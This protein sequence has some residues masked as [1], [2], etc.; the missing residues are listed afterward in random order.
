MNKKIKRLVILA[1][2][3]TAQAKEELVQAVYECLQKL[4]G[5]TEYRSSDENTL[6]IQE[7]ELRY[8]NT[9]TLL[10][11]MMLDHNYEIIAVI[12]DKEELML[13]LKSFDGYSHKKG[14]QLDPLPGT[15]T[16]INVYA[17][18]MPDTREKYFTEL[19]NQPIVKHLLLIREKI[20]PMLQKGG[21]IA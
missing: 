15:S 6:C 10:E 4:D 17:R 3:L 8:G 9:D 5:E 20:S 13:H 1:N 14:I 18:V 19:R 21:V 12:G 2:Q 11:K 16:A 7:G